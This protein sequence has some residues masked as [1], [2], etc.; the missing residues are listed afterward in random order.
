ME[1]ITPETADKI[2]DSNEEIV[3][4]K[5]DRLRLLGSSP[6]ILSHWRTSLCQFLIV[7]R[8]Y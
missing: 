4:K 6:N 1:E 7:L 8:K 5:L 3:E 2:S